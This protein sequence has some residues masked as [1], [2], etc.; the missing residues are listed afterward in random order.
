MVRSAWVFRRL[1]DFRA[2]PS[3]CPASMQGCRASPPAPPRGPCRP[4]LAHP[5][6]VDRRSPYRTPGSARKGPPLEPPFR[7]QERS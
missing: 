4:R 6:G 5:P 2:W 3:P 1:R 7:R